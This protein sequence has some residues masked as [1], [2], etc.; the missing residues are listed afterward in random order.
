MDRFGT[1]SLVVLGLFVATL[2]GVPAHALAPDKAFHQYVSDTWSLEEGL[3]QISVNAVVQGPRGYIWAGTQ[4][5]V[6]RFDGVRFTVFDPRTSPEMPGMFI[7]TLFVDSR[8]SIWAGTYKGAAV[9][10]DG[11]FHG[12]DDGFGR[13]ID[14][15]QFAETADG[16]VLLASDQ[17]LMRLADDAFVQFSG[18]PEDALR[19]VFTHRDRI[20]AGGYGVIHV[21]RDGAWQSMP[22]KGELEPALVNEFI[23]YDGRIWA[24]TTRGLLYLEDDAWKRF[25]VPGRLEDPVIEALHA[26]RDGNLWLGAAGRL[27]RIQGRELIESVPDE[28]P[29]A[30]G[31]VL[32]MTEDHE[33]NLWL[34]SRWDGLARLWN[35]WVFRYDKPEG[36]HNSLVWTVARDA[37]G[38]VWTGTMDGLAVY[39]DGRFEQLT[40]GSEQPHPHA[41]SVLPEEDRVW[42]GTRTGLY[43]WNRAEGRID[44]P[45]AFSPLDSAQVNGIIRFRGDYWLATTE[46]VWRWDGERMHRMAP[47]GD[48]GGRDVRL[49]YKTEDGTLLVGTRR[50]LLYWQGDRFERVE[51]VASERDV[52]AI[53]ELSDGR[54]AAG[55]LDEKLYIGRGSTWHE[56]GVEDGLPVN[57]P[58]AFG[59]AD[60]RLWVAGIRGIYELPLDS[61]QSYLDGEIEAL[62]GRM[63]LHERGDVTGAQKGY[64]CNGAG[65]AK[66]FMHEGEFWLPTRGGIV[67]LV[68]E[69]IKRNAAPPRVHVDRIRIDAQWRELE[70]GTSLD[71]PADKRDLAFGFAVMSYQDP[72]SV[73]VEYRLEGFRDEW[74]K[75]DEPMQRQAFYTNLPSGRYSLQ[76]RA[77][78]NAGI[79]VEKPASLEFRIQPYLWETVWFQI[80]LLIV[81]LMLIWLGFN[82]RLRSMQRRQRML[83][84]TVAERTDELRVANEHLRD[85]SARL[86]TA[87]MT[88]PLTG[89]WNRRYLASQLPADLA[90]FHRELSKPEMGRS[91]MTFA[92]I[93]IDH[94][95][96]V[97]D[98]YGHDAGDEVLRQFS[99]LLVQLV[100]TGDYV[101][102]WGGEEFLIV[103]RPMFA[104]EVNRV[105]ARLIEEIRGYEF[106]LDSGT[107]VRLTASMGV[108]E[109]PPFRDHPSALSW[110]QT[111]TLAD[112]ALLDIKQDGRDGWCRVR[113]TSWVEPVTL[114][115]HLDQ[116]LRDL[117]EAEEISVERG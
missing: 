30:H 113:P 32:D 63:V 51:G 34:G 71:L 29:Y 14:A 112:K 91:V 93:D 105:A 82:Y 74:Q 57:S 4:A 5:G 45:P 109:Y 48:L 98:R 66:G 55:T 67:H 96:E 103:F 17:G 81:L 83:E 47:S 25:E 92:V 95:K 99:R 35:G 20:F 62:P 56:F 115:E 27:V 44:K 15:F 61:I 117:L 104:G 79:W 6:A 64:C 16:E 116:P 97:N 3:P 53:M 10:R 102:R 52:T 84:T 22:L 43:W 86:E 85:Y 39:R 41:Y 94:F 12:V 9:F 78:N 36:L 21:Q 49:L 40:A 89:L 108:A 11:E 90:H 18:D 38:N 76:L 101:V 70:P 37:Q 100:R 59:E 8:G 19:S 7:Q 31:S 69:R 24:A 50:G 42:V 73:R 75:L 33:G 77:S 106:L 58:F 60:G 23:D 26:D 111:V 72:T 88:D 54:L 65:N 46:G 1:Q 13:E 68:P 87:S 80:F 110:S 28:A 107:V 114:R 2:A